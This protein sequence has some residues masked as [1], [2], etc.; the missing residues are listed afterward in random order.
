MSVATE[1]IRVYWQPGCTSCLRTKEFLTRYDIPFESRNVLGDPKA[2]EELAEFGL[3]QVPIV[4]KGKNWAN[5]QVLKDVADLVGIKGVNLTMLP[6]DELKRRL[7]LVLES[8]ERFYQQLPDSALHAMLPN[9]PRSYTDLVYHI[10][11][12][13]DAFL[14]EKAG[15]PLTFES[16]NRFPA[17]EVNGREEILRYIRDVQKNVAAWFDGPGKQFGWKQKADVYYGD[18]NQHQFLERTVWHSAQHARQLMW[19]LEGLSVKVDRPIPPETFEGLPMPQ[20]VW[21]DEKIES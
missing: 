2:F 14:E 11:N 7:M 16:Y 21:D 8:S 1:V 19:V 5:G 6:V 12:N 15:I 20:K 3:R 17:P 10:F 13:A 9:R 4:T 18:Q